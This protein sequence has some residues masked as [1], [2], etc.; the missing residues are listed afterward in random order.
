MSSWDRSYASRLGV[1]GPGWAQQCYDLLLAKSC[2][3]LP[4]GRRSRWLSTSLSA[5]YASEGVCRGVACR[6]HRRARDL[7]N[8]K[9]MDSLEAASRAFVHIPSRSRRDKPREGPLQSF[10][11]LAGAGQASVGHPL[12]LH[13]RG[14]T[15]FA[16][17]HLPPTFLPRWMGSVGASRFGRRFVTEVGS[18]PYFDEPCASL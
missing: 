3:T 17:L 11:L 6:A 18:I 1:H 5:T 7:V 16:H 8:N 14:S 9:S 10:L 2:V 15:R 4:V 13:L 12:A